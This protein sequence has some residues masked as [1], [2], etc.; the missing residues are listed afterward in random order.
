MKEIVAV[1]IGGTHARFAIATV[2]C[3]RVVSLGEATTLR[4]AEHAS[5]QLAWE[6]FARQIGQSLPRAAGIAVACPVQGDILKMTNN[7]WIIQP[8]QLGAKLGVDE[9][10]L[11]NDFGAVGHAVAQV[12]ASHLRHLCGP[13]RPLPESG[14]TTI[15]GP[16]TG[17]GSAYVVRRDG[18]YLVCETEGGHVDLSPLDQV[19]DQ[20]LQRLRRRYRRV[21]AE[22]IVSGPGLVNLYEAIAEIEDQSVHTRDDKELWTRALDGRDHM[23]SAALE[24]FCLALGAVAGDLALAQGG[25]SVVIAGGLGLRLAD[26]LPNSGF[27]ER[28]VAK[29]RF[30]S[31]MADMPVKLITHPQPGLFGAAAAF[32]ERFA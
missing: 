10:V 13:D 19:E 27:A 30:E 23:A 15:V 14:V 16:G 9:H 3:G 18:R 32:A 11:V 8:A 7:P 6:A 17:L 28:F 1:D 29:G 4:C 24:R 5:L 12:D 2:D 22:R 21:S 31:M 20:I 26:H 25:N